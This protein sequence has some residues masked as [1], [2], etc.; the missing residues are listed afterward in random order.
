MLVKKG[1]AWGGRSRAEGLVRVC[2]SPLKSGSYMGGLIWHSIGSCLSLFS[3]HTL[4]TDEIPILVDYRVPSKL[5]FS[6]MML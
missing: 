3:S 4:M 2:T 5:E 6:E 1:E